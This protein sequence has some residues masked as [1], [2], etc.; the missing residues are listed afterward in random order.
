MYVPRGIEIDVIFTLQAAV[1]TVRAYFHNCLGMKPG[2]C[3]ISR[4]CIM[5]YSLSTTVGNYFNST[6]SIFRD[7]GQFSPVLFKIS[8]DLHM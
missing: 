1:S 3:K 5:M 8:L 2:I 7:A 6:G 4:S